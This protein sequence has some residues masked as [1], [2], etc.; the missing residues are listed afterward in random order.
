MITEAAADAGPITLMLLPRIVT[1]V[2]H[3]LAPG[4]QIDTPE[5]HERLV[6]LWDPVSGAIA[7]GVNYGAGKGG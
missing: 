5:P 7:G 6:D 2:Q 4:A 3:L 1:D